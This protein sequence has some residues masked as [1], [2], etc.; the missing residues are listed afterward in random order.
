MSS[1]QTRTIGDLGTEIV[2][3]EPVAAENGT[4]V[5]SHA[6]CSGQH[7]VMGRNARSLPQAEKT[8]CGTPSCCRS[9]RATLAL[10]VAR[11]IAKRDMPPSTGI[12][13]PV[14]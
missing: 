5:R 3:A 11:H 13:V 10:A 12:T 4:N 9:R 8:A 2:A 1:L 6:E 7:V 14:M